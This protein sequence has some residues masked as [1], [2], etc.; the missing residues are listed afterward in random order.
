MRLPGSLWTPRGERLLRPV[1]GGAEWSMLGDGQRASAE[2]L[3]SASTD[4]TTITSSDTAD[5]KGIYVELVA[6]TPFDCSLLSVHHFPVF[7][8]AVGLIDIAVG[9]AG[10]EQVIIANLLETLQ[11]GRDVNRTLWPISIPAG[12]RISARVQDDEATAHPHHIGLYLFE[13]G[14]LPSQPLSRVTT[15]GAQTGDSSGTQIDPGAVINTKGS[16]IEIDAS[17]ANDIRMLTILVGTAG[18]NTSL[19]TA[20]FYLDVGVGAG[21]SEQIVLP[22]ALFLTTTTT[23]EYHPNPCVPGVPVNIPAGSRLAV[24]SQ[25][26]INNAADRVFD[27]I[28]YGLD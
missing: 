20:R 22:D 4:W 15:Y 24:R 27:L 19:S 25:C 5:T 26:T 8:Q 7:A 1:R 2:G 14:F 6:S 28:A 21:G 23:D 16:W 12:T 3:V 13:A 11:V 9:G 17:I 10:S 18:G